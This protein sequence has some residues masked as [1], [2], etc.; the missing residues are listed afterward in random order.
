MAV[1]TRI[2]MG[3]GKKVY[4]QQM[5]CHRLYLHNFPSYVILGA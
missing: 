4:D 3:N 1:K 2:D 5:I